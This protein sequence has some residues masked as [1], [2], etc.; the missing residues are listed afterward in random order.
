MFPLVFAFL[1]F[2]CELNAEL[3]QFYWRKLRDKFSSPCRKRTRHKIIQ[4]RPVGYEQ[5]K[6]KREKLYSAFESLCRTL[7]EITK[8]KRPKTPRS[9][10]PVRIKLSAHKT[11]P[12]RLNKLGR[13]IVKFCTDSKENLLNKTIVKSFLEEKYPFLAT[14]TVEK[15]VEKIVVMRKKSRDHNA[16][17]NDPKLKRF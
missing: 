3:F 9:P 17:A 11:S 6:S 4:V 8:K 5:K 15:M 10:K 16:N 7:K 2:F 13:K 12:N 1:A 14:L